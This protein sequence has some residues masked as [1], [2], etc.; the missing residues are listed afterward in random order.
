MEER[1]NTYPETFDIGG[2]GGARI[3]VL[4]IV[5]EPRDVL[6]AVQG[7]NTDTSLFRHTARTGGQINTTHK[8]IDALPLIFFII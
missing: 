7:W 6:V 2:S 8:L 5:T 1:I 3:N 4:V